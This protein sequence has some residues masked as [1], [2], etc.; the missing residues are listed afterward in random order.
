[1]KINMP[2]TDKEVL[3]KKD[4]IL[5]TRTDLKGKII[6]ANDAFVAISGYSREELIGSNHNIVRHPDMPSAAFEDLWIC[7]KQS[8]PWTALVKNRTKS[9]DYYWVEANVT[10]IFQNGV[11][12]EYLSARY[13]PKREQIEKA[14][15]FYKELNAKTKTM[16]PTGVFAAIKFIQEISLWKK[17]AFS[18]LL[19]LGIISLLCYRLFIAEE[20]LLLSGV[21]VLTL[22]ALTVN[23]LLTKTF[24]QCLEHS[25]GVMYRMADEKFRNP[26]PLNRNDQVG[27]FYRGLYGM[28]V[29]LNADIAEARQT[30]T[31]ALRINQALDNVQS[32]VMVTNPNL[33]IIYM[34]KF[35]Y[36][37][38]ND[39]EQQIRKQLPHFD[40][41]KLMGANIDMFHKNPA[42]QRGML[43]KLT[44]TYRSELKIGDLDMAVVVNPVVDKKGDRIGFVAE[45]SDRALE[46][47]L[48]Q[49][50]S[51]VVSAATLGDFTQRVNEQDKSGLYLKLT[52]NIN[53]LMETSSTAL[54]EVARVLKALSRG[55]LT[56]K[57]TN[58]YAGTFQQLK[59][60]ANTTVDSLKEIVGTIKESTDSI[61]TAAKEIAA[62]NADLSHRTEQQAASLEETAASMEELA[63]TVKQNVDN[64]RQARQMAVTASDVAVKGGNVVQQVIGTMSAINE[65][66]RKI[67]DIISVIDG[68]ALQTNILALNA[69]VEAARA[70]EQGRGFAVVASEVRNLAQRS[71]AA[72]KEIKGLISD[73]VEKVED[74]S[75]QV[76]EAGRTM[77]EIVASVNRVTDIMSEIA[78]ASVEQSSG[79]DLVNQA[80][81]QMD[82]VTQQNA[83]LVEQAAAAAESLEEQAGTLSDTM[84]QFRLDTVGRHAAAPHRA[85]SL[86]V[87]THKP[88]VRLVASAAKPSHQNDDEWSEF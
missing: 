61:N 46:V 70:G 64:A 62:G 68:I 41:K 31:D 83:A 67:V 66:S 77:E 76:G 33:N 1:M 2:V 15:R 35:A 6:F 28:Q 32:G 11:A 60:D 85:A 37:L 43:D 86:Q 16:R 24:D 21:A 42:H 7:L 5:V 63:S 59:D 45:W 51:K 79:I 78:A 14:E 74:G 17:S 55:D 82:E 54:S 10:P 48:D 30:G 81:T 39:K 84:A 34:N 58:A 73:S 49:E 26:M 44:S 9:G 65:S 75:K 29:K 12:H 40:A 23:T 57:I 71:A 72:A 80:V 50:I 18:S 69:A 3:M 25:I 88:A 22:L 13:A 4:D 38:F 87:V 36:Q 52:Q 56:E 27:D 53:Q 20:F 19:L 8:R 47:M